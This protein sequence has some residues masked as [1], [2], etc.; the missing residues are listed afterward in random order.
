[1]QGNFSATGLQEL[2]NDNFSKI[3]NS[4]VKIDFSNFTFLTKDLKI[5][6]GK[7]AL[8]F[9]ATIENRNFEFN[10]DIIF[11]G[12]RTATLIIDGATFPIDWNF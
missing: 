11:N 2:K 4:E 5:G 6:S 3:L 9:T 8:L 10:G 7:G 1:M 12:D